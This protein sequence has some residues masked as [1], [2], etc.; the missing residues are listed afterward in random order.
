MTYVRSTDPNGKWGSVHALMDWIY[1][2]IDGLAYSEDFESIDKI[3][4]NTNVHY[5]PL[6]LLLT[7]LTATLP[8]KSIKL[9]S[10]PI[11][12]NTD[13]TYSRKTET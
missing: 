13:K 4:I 7:L 6:Y 8:M 10:R 2:V 11:Y 3:L 12:I 9:S 1:D 5:C